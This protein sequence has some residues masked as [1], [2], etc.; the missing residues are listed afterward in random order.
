MNNENK[1]TLSQMYTKMTSED[2]SKVKEFCEQTKMIFNEAVEKYN[3]NA[4]KLTNIRLC[5]FGKSDTCRTAS[6][7]YAPKRYF[8]YG[9]RIEAT[10]LHNLMRS[11]QNKFLIDN[12]YKAV[13]S[14]ETNK[15][16]EFRFSFSSLDSALKFFSTLQSNYH[17]QV[18]NAKEVKAKELVE[19][20]E[21]AV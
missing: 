16:N 2:I 7:W 4:D 6:I 11:E 13:E 15:D 5:N 12:C 3:F 19:S 8:D 20:E 10:T 1:I 14:Q 9:V 21:K 17:R 18:V